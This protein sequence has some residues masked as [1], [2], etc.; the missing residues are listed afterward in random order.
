M[1]PIE[2]KEE[3][4]TISFSQFVSD[5]KPKT[6]KA[7]IIKEFLKNLR[8]L[9]AQEVAQ[10]R[11]ENKRNSIQITVMSEE[12]FW[13]C[14]EKF[15]NLESDFKSTLNFE[16]HECLEEAIEKYTQAKTLEKKIAKVKRRLNP[17]L[18]KYHGKRVYINLSEQLKIYEKI[19]KD[20]QNNVPKEK[21]MCKYNITSNYFRAVKCYLKKRKKK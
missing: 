11:R 19:E 20:L 13:Q 12:H 6:V 15:T 1:D 4:K 2:P 18:D 16:A 17:L 3:E 7:K 5:L 21:I 9:C 8:Y 14:F 10:N